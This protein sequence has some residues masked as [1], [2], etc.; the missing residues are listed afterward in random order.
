MQTRFVS[1]PYYRDLAINPLGGNVGIGT[2]SPEQKLEVNS[3][4]SSTIVTS[5]ASDD[6]SIAFKKGA[7]ATPTWRIGR[8][9]SNSD[10]LSFAY[11]A[12][13]YPSL[14]GSYKVV[15]TTGGNAT[16]S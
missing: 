11:L 4:G 12:N 9:T 16:G 8:D 14:T 7:G 6:C 2:N 10:A 3:S 5:S 1:A 15:M 13:G